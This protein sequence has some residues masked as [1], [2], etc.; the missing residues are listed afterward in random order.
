[1]ERVLVQHVDADVDGVVD[2]LPGSSFAVAYGGGGEAF[3][4]IGNLVLNI[5]EFFVAEV[6]QAL[7]TLGI[8]VDEAAGF[9]VAKYGS[10]RHHS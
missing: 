6:V 3:G 5:V 9:A 1:M 4:H 2:D 10:V 8:D 7:P